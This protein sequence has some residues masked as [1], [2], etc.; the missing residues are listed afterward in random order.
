MA[1][2]APPRRPFQ[3][4]LPPVDSSRRDG[5]A[6]IA[7]TLRYAPLAFLLGLFTP[8]LEVD[9]QPVPASWGRV[10][11]SV[12][13][14]PHLVHVHIP[15]LVPSRIGAAETT[16]IAVPGRTVELEYRAPLLSFMAGALGS[17]PQRYPGLVAAVILLVTALSL[18]VCG[19]L[20]ILLSAGTPA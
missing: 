16:V 15:Y 6:N 19:C 9:G 20:G 7:V 18:A 11:T 5:G 8:V 2:Q 1:I 14:G 3:P 4:G 10:V 13:L 17:P 12:A